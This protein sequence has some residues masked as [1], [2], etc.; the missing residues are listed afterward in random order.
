MKKQASGKIS[1]EKQQVRTRTVH[2]EEK[3]AR[4]KERKSK[5]NKIKSVETKWQKDKIYV[6]VKL[7]LKI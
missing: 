2:Q 6:K 3:R 1:I 5:G 7:Y 4:E